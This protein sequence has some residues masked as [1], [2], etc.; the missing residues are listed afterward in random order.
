MPVFPVQLLQM[1]E[2]YLILTVE[3]AFVAVVCVLLLS[4][5]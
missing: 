2:K 3:L 5:R 4:F 1:K